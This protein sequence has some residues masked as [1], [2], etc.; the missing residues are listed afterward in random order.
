MICRYFS[1]R[2]TCYNTGQKLGINMLKIVVFDGGLGG[3]TV[4]NFLS[5]ELQVTE[6][7]QVIDWEHAPYDGK[8]TPEICAAAETCLASY[9]GKV[10]LIVLGGYAAAQSLDYLREH[11]PE[12]NFVAVGV[13]YHRIL[14]SAV[15]PDRV[16]VI[17][18]N[19][20]IDTDFCQNLRQNLPYS[21]LSIP[22]SN[23]WE[24]LTNI[25]EL[26]AEILHR[27][28]G[29]Y[30]EVAPRLPSDRPSAHSQ[31][32]LLEG[33]IDQKKQNQYFQPPTEHWAPEE[34]IHSDVVLLLNTNFWSLKP[35][36]EAVFGYRVRVLDFRQKLLHDTCLALGLRGVHGDRSK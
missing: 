32:T 8:S 21:T 18:N 13:N 25:G 34:R 36:V 12:Q 19:N 6:V 11:Y 16:T 30:F 3:E 22:D 28:L 15:Y 31:K 35:I 10:D 26:S 14:K 2:M 17:M 9:F 27:E 4:A 1:S 20:L 7:I 5:H 24:S 23:G 29:A 33:L